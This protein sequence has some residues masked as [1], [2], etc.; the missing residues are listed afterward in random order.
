MQEHTAEPN[1]N[2]RAD[3]SH[4]DAEHV[5]PV[6][7]IRHSQER[8]GQ[9]A[10]LVLVEGAGEGEAVLQPVAAER[11]PGVVELEPGLRVARGL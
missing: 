10:G 3:E 7:R 8:P 11:V 6:H 2:H 5:D 9:I 4:D 1:Q